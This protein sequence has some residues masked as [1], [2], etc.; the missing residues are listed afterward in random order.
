MIHKVGAAAFVTAAAVLLSGCSSG[1][2]VSEPDRETCAA[3]AEL[4]LTTQRAA[5][6]TTGS[7]G[8][9]FVYPSG[10]DAFTTQTSAQH[11]LAALS[12][13]AASDDRLVRA[14]ERAR[15]DAQATVEAQVNDVA[16]QASTL[17]ASLSAIGSVCEDL[18]A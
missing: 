18:G 17:R 5:K 8:G 6:T 9:R 2:E 1:S 3:A 14:V 4:V 12:G 10:P 13:T 15:N 16:D 11:I 7:S